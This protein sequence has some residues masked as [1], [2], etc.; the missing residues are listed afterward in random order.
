[1]SWVLKL[2]HNLLSTIPLVRKAIEVFLRKA[3]QPSKII[4][5]EEV[6]GLANI[7]ENQYVIWLVDTPKPT[8]V[9]RITALTIETWHAQ[10]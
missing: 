7:I 6:F 8:I 4:V 5:D 9:N 3:S 1:M 10:I 2:G